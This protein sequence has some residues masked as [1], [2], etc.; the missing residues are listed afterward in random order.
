MN[1]TEKKGVLWCGNAEEPQNSVKGD[2]RA[3]GHQ[4][5]SFIRFHPTCMF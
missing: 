2:F 4:I 5:L 1:E 3:K